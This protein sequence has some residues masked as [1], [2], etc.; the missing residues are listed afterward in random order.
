MSGRIVVFTNGNY[1]SRLILERLMVQHSGDISAV[2]LVSADYGNRS[3]L[4]R[5]IHLARTT[6]P[7]YVGYLLF[8]IATF[9]M[10]Q[11]V[12]RAAT[13]DVA[14]L[15]ARAGV[16]IAECRS[17][18]SKPAMDLVRQT[19]PDLIVSVSCPQRIP[20][21]LLDLA[22][23]G[24][25]NIHAS[26]LPRY[27]GL[28]P[29]F[30]VLSCGERETGISAHYIADKVDSGNILVQRTLPI[31][32]GMSAF[33]LFLDLA[34]LGQGVLTEAVGLALAK[35]PGLPQAPEQR[36]YRSHP[37]PPAYRALR[38]NGHVLMRLRELIDACRR[39]IARG[40]RP[41]ER[42]R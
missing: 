23:C 25:I 35:E 33:A 21:N 2:I 14:R 12:F 29:Y 13:F 31:R 18:T 28:A 16:L 8:Q 36:S 6:D 38:R 15:A 11:R 9:A 5:V 26:A 3:G 24:G 1:F 20:R 39:E 41:F 4:A 30:W 37:S 34:V 10:L 32:P 22:R 7:H 19:R 40:R 17:V 42:L 27:A